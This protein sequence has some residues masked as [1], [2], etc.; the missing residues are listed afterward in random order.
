MSNNRPSFIAGLVLILLGI[1]FLLNYFIP[2][3]WPVLII[4]VGVVFVA[5]AALLGA[6]GLFMPALIT[7]TVGGILLYQTNTDDWRSWFFLW[8]LLFTAVGLGML[9][10]AQRHVEH[11]TLGS[12]YMRVSLAFVLLSVLGTVVLWAFRA[13]I[14]WPSIIWGIGALFLL[15]A[16][17]A[18]VGPLAIPGTILGCLGLLLA[19]QN[20]TGVWESWAYAWALIP[21]SVGLGL[22]LGF[23]R[24]RVMRIIGL[25]MLGW[26]LVVFVLFGIFFAGDGQ[27]TS[28]W[29]VALI[30]AGLVILLQTMFVSRRSDHPS[31]S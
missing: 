9:I 18:S 5:A 11:R 6:S 26:S 1:L 13:T 24:K 17:F 29:P 12:R 27:F 16:L 15:T 7:L 21:A 23:L 10:D 2:T 20:A 25:T 30:L 22:F 4:A 28:L 8:P 3:A 19:W 14:T 31:S